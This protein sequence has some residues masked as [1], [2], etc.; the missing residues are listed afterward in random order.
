M[1]GRQWSEGRRSVE[2]E[3]EEKPRGWGYV[4]WRREDWPAAG[5]GPGALARGPHLLGSLL[6]FTPSGS[7]EAAGTRAAG[8]A[9]SPERLREPDGSCLLCPPKCM[10]QRYCCCST[11]RV[12]G[13]TRGEGRAHGAPQLFPRGGGRPQIYASLFGGCGR[14][15]EPQDGPAPTSLNSQDTLDPRPRALSLSFPILN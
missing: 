12:S 7:K 14:F 9:R 4:A 2:E 6:R 11:S 15:I 1:R 3:E 5:R 10:G 13:R 8:R